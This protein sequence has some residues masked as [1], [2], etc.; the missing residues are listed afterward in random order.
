MNPAILPIV[1]LAAYAGAASALPKLWPSSPDDP[2]AQKWRLEPGARWTQE[3]GEMVLEV[4]YDD[5]GHD[6]FGAVFAI[7]GA[8]LHDRTFRLRGEM[9]L[10]GVARPKDAPG[11]CGAKFMMSYTTHGVADYPEPVNMVRTGTTDW[12]ALE[13]AFPGFP[14]DV[15]IAALTLGLGASASLSNEAPPVPAQSLAAPADLQ[16]SARDTVALLSWRPVPGSAGYQVVVDAAPIH[17]R[18]VRDFVLNPLNNAD[19]NALARIAAKLRV[20]PADLA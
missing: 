20:R 9:A 8:A 18:A 16:A 17:V 14:D 19:Q 5:A 4:V 1:F 3:N 12:K 7:D 2:V 10:D 15:A 13:R 6:E 11:F